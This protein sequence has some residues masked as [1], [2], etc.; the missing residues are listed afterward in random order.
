MMK[1]EEKPR[2]EIVARS[3][4]RPSDYQPEVREGTREAKF[5]PPLQGPHNTLPDMQMS[6]L[7]ASAKDRITLGGVPRLSFQRDVAGLR[8]KDIRR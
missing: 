8:T 1:L 5:G 4:S 6:H 2:R 7:M 3:S